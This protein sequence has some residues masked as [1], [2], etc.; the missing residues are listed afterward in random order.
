[1]RVERD[2]VRAT[3]LSVPPSQSILEGAAQG[4]AVEHLDGEDPAGDGI[5]ADCAMSGRERD[6]LSAASPQPTGLVRRNDVEAGAGRIVAPARLDNPQRPHQP[7]EVAPAR[8][9]E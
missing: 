4:G 5:D 7:S 3:C 6:C 1:M 8:A 9:E 2:P